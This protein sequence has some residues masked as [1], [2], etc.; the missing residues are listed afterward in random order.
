MVDALLG[1]T[2]E[3]FRAFSQEVI[4]RTDRFHGALY[5]QLMRDGVFD[6][7]ASAIA[8]EL[9]AQAIA[10][11]LEQA[12]RIVLPAVVQEQRSAEDGTATH[13]FLLRLED[14]LEV[15]TVVI[16]MRGGRHFT[17]CVSSQVGC[18]MGCSFCHTARMG[19]LR[20]LLPHEMVGQVIR[21]S[22]ASALPVRNVVFMGMG[23]PLDNAEAVAQAIQVLSDRRG[24]AVASRHITVSTVGRVEVL[25]RW[26]ELGFGAVNLAVSLG[27]A[28]DALRSQLMPIN[29]SANL[30]TLKR[31]LQAMPLAGS[32][33]ILLSYIVIPGI[34]DSPQQVQNLVG[35]VAGLPV[36][37]N[38]IPYNPIPS[39]SWRA[40]SGREL[41]QVRIA[42][43]R[44]GVP[45]RLRVTKGRA[46][47][48]ACGQLG[49]PQR[50]RQPRPA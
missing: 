23:E 14:G 13:K 43:H 24:L 22:Q 49:D 42:L 20:N 17:V 5:R 30:E 33:R 47:M 25:A 44:Q 19:L 27:A 10:R 21:V 31:T 41:E 29:R 32:R 38:L 2:F 39:R 35:Y 37:V 8:P 28:D 6:P 4:G 15:E 3:A 50:A 9:P 26:R 36:M 7:S 46:V 1:L 45:V 12:P 16:P 18:R 48:A 40:P 11:L 34:N